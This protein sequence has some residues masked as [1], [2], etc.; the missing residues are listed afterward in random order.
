LPP[1]FVKSFPVIWQTIMPLH[2]QRRSNAF[3]H[4]AADFGKVSEKESV[5]SV[6]ELAKLKAKSAPRVEG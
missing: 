5:C 4:K 2:S 3:Q 6:H 1:S